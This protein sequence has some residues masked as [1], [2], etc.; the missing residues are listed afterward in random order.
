[1]RDALIE[2]ALENDFG[3]INEVTIDEFL[4]T[5]DRARRLELGGTLLSLALHETTASL[6]DTYRLSYRNHQL[7]P[8]TARTVGKFTMHIIKRSGH[9]RAINALDTKLRAVA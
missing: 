2:R 9:T 8:N 1:V 6:R 3:G 4:S 7:P 5:V